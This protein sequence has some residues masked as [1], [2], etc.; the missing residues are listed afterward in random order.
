MWNVARFLTM[1]LALSLIASVAAGAAFQAH[2]DEC[3]PLLD[4]RQYAQALDVCTRAAGQ[5]DPAAQFGL[6][7]MYAEGWGAKKNAT[8]SLQWL[9]ASARQGYPPAEYALASRYAAGSGVSRDRKE[10]VRLLVQAADHGF[11]L[12]QML[13]ARAHESGYP[14]LGI[15]K[16]LDEAVRWYRKAAAQCE[17]CQYALWRAYYFGRGVE[18][19]ETEAARHLQRAAEAG[20]PKAQ[21]QLAFRYNK[22]EGVP[23][24]AVKAYMWFYIAAQ[25]GDPLAKKALPLS[26]R[27]ISRSQATE[28]RS[29]AR[30]VMERPIDKTQLCELYKQ[31]CDLK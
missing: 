4:A 25:G 23:K 2:T 17:A 19:N 12:A 11:L 14:Y 29:M 18:R 1:F 16:D 9:Q 15:D 3:R 31:F 13:L 8:T 30:I 5:G 26:A 10:S 28:A 7:V 27:K 22:G 20:L 6:S 24:D 21:M